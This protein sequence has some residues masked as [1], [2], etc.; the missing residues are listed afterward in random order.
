V[1]SIKYT[2][3]SLSIQL[4][5]TKYVFSLNECSIQPVVNCSE[6]RI[7]K[8]VVNVN[9]LFSYIRV[10]AVG[11][12]NVGLYLHVFVAGLLVACIRNTA[13]MFSC[14][15]TCSGS[16]QGCHEQVRQRYS[17]LRKTPEELGD[18]QEKVFV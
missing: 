17:T 12:T 18:C 3:P 8:C 15:S 6:V 14:I 1:N 16:Q 10:K 13:T 9:C 11:V 7:Y 5:Y 2:S 4:T